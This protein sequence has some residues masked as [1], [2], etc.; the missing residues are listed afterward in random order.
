MGALGAYVTTKAK[1]QSS[2]APSSFAL[3][4]NYPNPFNPSTII[5]YQLAVNS[6]V[7]LKV[8]DILGREAATL[9]E[10][11]QNAGGH[12]VEFNAQNLASGVYFYRLTA[13]GVDFA[14]KMLLMK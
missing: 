6:N 8:Y 11:Y 1:A 14:K 4:Q 5:S 10:G 3:N 13:P 2:L 7:T 12:Q 9:V